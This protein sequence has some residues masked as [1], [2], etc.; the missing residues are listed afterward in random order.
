MS[1]DGE[2]EWFL[3]AEFLDVLSTARRRVTVVGVLASVFGVFGLAY[4]LGLAAHGFSGPV[5][6]VKVGFLGAHAVGMGIGLGLLNHSG[7][8]RSAGSVWFVAWGVVNLIVGFAALDAEDPLLGLFTFVT[9]AIHLLFSA[10]LNSAEIV[11]LCDYVGPNITE[12][13]TRKGLQA[14]LAGGTVEM[15]VF[16]NSVINPLPPAAVPPDDAP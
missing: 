14:A 12:E 10:V 3:P 4:M 6:M 5:T 9:G 11:F 15:Q 2:R 7:G 16:A 1:T 8:A 13:A